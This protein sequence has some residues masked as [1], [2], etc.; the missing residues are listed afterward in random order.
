MKATVIT[1]GLLF[2]AGMSAMGQDPELQYGLDF[3]ILSTQSGV[4]L[5]FENL[6]V[7]TVEPDRTKQAYANYCPSQQV[8]ETGY[9]HGMKGTTFK[10][11]AQNGTDALAG[12]SSADGY[13]IVFNAWYDK[14]RSASLS[15]AGTW[16]D[17]I[18]F[19]LAEATE[20][21]GY[22]YKHYKFETGAGDGAMNIFGAADTIVTLANGMDK[23]WYTY[24]LNLQNGSGQFLVYDM[25]GTNVSTT[26]ISGMTG[27]LV[28]LSGAYSE[29]Q[30]YD[31]IQLKHNTL[32][33][34]DNVGI[35]NSV[36]TDENIR[37]LIHTSAPTAPCCYTSPSRRPPRSPCWRWRASHPAAVAAS[38]RIPIILFIG[39]PLP[40]AGRGRFF[41]RHLHFTCNRLCNEV[42]CVCHENQSTGT[43]I[44]RR[45][46]PAL[47]L[48][49]HRLRHLVLRGTLQ[50]RRASSVCQE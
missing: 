47:R 46:R 21:G 16:A 41:V 9:A 3:N 19:T 8:G 43:P 26:N 32:A 29:L 6:G 23:A 30:G 33:A 17:L 42:Y 28:F 50:C 13:S 2:G 18:A 38:K 4:G 15:E 35:Y 39:R 37:M 25:D 27:E 44:H 7:Q 45:S 49:A 34:V 1:L 12:V 40:H 22:A 24:V 36:L 10:F 5:T 14:T 11:G 20:A 31:A 48:P